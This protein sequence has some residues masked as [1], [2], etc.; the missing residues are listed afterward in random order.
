MRPDMR[1]TTQHT[2]AAAAWHARLDRGANAALRAEFERWL[3]LDLQHRMAYADICALAYA[4]EQAAPE[5]R[6]AF[7][8]PARR[9]P[10]RGWLAG[11]AL[12]LLLVLTVW[13]GARPWD[14]WRADLA[15]AEGESRSEM[16]ADG[17][18]VWLGADS[19]LALDFSAA[20]RRVHVLRGE[21]FFE[22]RSDPARP[23]SVQAAEVEATAVGTRYAV[24]HRAAGRIAVEVEEGIVALAV[25][26]GTPTR[27]TAGDAA[28]VAPDGTATAGRVSRSAFAWREGVLV[29]DEAPVADVV[30]R[31]DAWIPGRVV[32]LA[33]SQARLSA[34]IALRDPGS[35]RA[36]LLALAAR[37]GWRA[38]EV[39][40]VLLV[41]H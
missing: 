18:R 17:S 41:L 32:L 2:A 25:A 23:F 35:A 19:A 1:Q 24:A 27:L 12:A 9:A 38:D 29:F 36:A 4:L 33:P 20:A 14:R 31:L 3:A 40:G 5:S 21:A 28:S 10:V 8:S 7:A 26:R 13:Q 37:E 6:A 39:P 16:L 22:V 34:A 11:A 15:T 30:A